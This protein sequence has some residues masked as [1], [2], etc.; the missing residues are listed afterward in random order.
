MV[1]IFACATALLSPEFV[2][3][4]EP[5]T[6]ASKFIKVEKE[7]SVKFK[8]TKSSFNIIGHW[9]SVQDA[10]CSLLQLIPDKRSAF[11]PNLPKSRPLEGCTPSDSGLLDKA[12]DSTNLVTTI[13]EE[14]HHEV[15]PADNTSGG[16]Q[17]CRIK[18]IFCCSPSKLGNLWELLLSL[19]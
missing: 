12:P 1:Q 4:F 9:K 19:L 13:D 10:H 7:Y 3:G 15:T 2:E 17:Y 14:D 18:G 5:E 16:E 11:V 8:K 6:L